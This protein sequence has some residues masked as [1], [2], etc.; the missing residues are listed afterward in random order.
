MFCSKLISIESS[1]E[2]LNYYKIW[3]F[4]ARFERVIGQRRSYL[5]ANEGT[6]HPPWDQSAW[7]WR[8]MHSNTFEPT[9]NK[10]FLRP[11]SSNEPFSNLKKNTLYV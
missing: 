7:K 8:G 1:I 4:R 3:N 2:E 6:F 10:F 9:K 5:H 11:I